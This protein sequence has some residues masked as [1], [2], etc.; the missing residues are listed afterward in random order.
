MAQTDGALL[1]AR[2]TELEADRARLWQALERQQTTSAELLRMLNVEQQTVAALTTPRALQTPAKPATAGAQMEIYGAAG[3]ETT[4]KTPP[5][6]K[7]A[8]KQAGVKGK[9]LQ[10]R[11]FALFG[12]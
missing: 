10:R 1:H 11:L 2:I 9:K 12:G 6:S 4:E 3:V 5:L 8:L 7:Q